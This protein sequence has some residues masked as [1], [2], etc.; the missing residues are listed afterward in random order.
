M[1]KND[2]NAYLKNSGCGILKPN[3]SEND[4][5]MLQYLDGGSDLDDFVRIHLNQFLSHRVINGIRQNKQRQTD[6]FWL[7][8]HVLFMGLK[9]F[10][11]KDGTDY[12]LNGSKMFI[13]GGSF[14]SLYIV[15]VK[16]SPT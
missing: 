10:A 4:Y 15:M 16:T 13:S 8:A 6:L 11:K 12:I 1:S 7:N 9:A 14:S 5:K 3:T 2:Y